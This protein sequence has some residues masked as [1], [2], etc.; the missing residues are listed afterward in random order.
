[1]FFSKSRNSSQTKNRFVRTE[2]HYNVSSRTVQRPK[3][4]LNSRT[5]A[6]REFLQRQSQPEL[7]QS[8]SQLSN[9][10]APF[11]PGFLSKVEHAKE[12][13]KKSFRI[14]SKHLQSQANLQFS[15]QVKKPNLSI[16]TQPFFPQLPATTKDCQQYEQMQ[17]PHQG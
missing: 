17:M 13:D 11:V 8:D 4:Q 9:D 2:S 12:L 15:S 10:L 1:M 5:Y 7:V 16:L 6:T 3:S 14:F